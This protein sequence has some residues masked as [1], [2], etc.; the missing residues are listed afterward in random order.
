VVL[1]LVLFYFPRV[2]ARCTLMQR[3]DAGQRSGVGLQAGRSWLEVAS[4]TG[5]R[6]ILQPKHR[7]LPL[8]ATEWCGKEKY[9]REG[10]NL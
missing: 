7:E 5:D 3:R 4:R 6:A 8:V 1:S 9:P 10:S 2:A